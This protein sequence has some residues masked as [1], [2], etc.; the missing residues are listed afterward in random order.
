ML[1]PVKRTSP[2]LVSA[3]LIFSACAA[4][5]APGSVVVVAAWEPG[6]AP[7][8]VQA[9]PQSASDPAPRPG[10]A[11]RFLRLPSP[12]PAAVPVRASIEVPAAWGIR[13]RAGAGRALRPCQVS[14]SSPGELFVAARPKG[15]SAAEH[16]QLAA[17]LI[18]AQLVVRGEMET[19]STQIRG[20]DASLALISGHRDG[21]VFSTFRFVR[22]AADARV[23]VA[24]EAFL[25]D[26][27]VRWLDAYEAACAT[28]GLDPEEWQDG[29]DELPA[30]P[31]GEPRPPVDEGVAQA[32]LGYV[33]ALGARDETAAATFLLTAPECIAAGG[34]PDPCESG[35]VERRAD[36]RLIID[37]IP[38]ESTFS[39]ADVRAPGALPGLVIA[40][41]K[42]RGDPC[43][44]GWDVTLARA[45]G[46]HAVV[47][48]DPVPDPLLLR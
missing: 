34:A 11:R 21:R 29:P 43:G 5:A 32:A 42:R 33:S 8:P 38:F 37:R 6:P 40:T 41:V 39:T 47:S 18:S 9:A 44:P 10:R 48:A 12:D 27:E 1:T 28:L 20:P 2:L 30:A 36:I 46:R 4:P 26:D 25:F 23:Q 17:D 24:C 19:Q 13:V 3:A 45:E 31:D 35:A 14:P 15:A 16:E 7:P 22:A